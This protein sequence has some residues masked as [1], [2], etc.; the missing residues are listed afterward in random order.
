MSPVENARASTREFATHFLA[1]KW[2]LR[3][4]HVRRTLMVV[5]SGLRSSI[6]VTGGDPAA[7]YGTGWRPCFAGHPSDLA[8]SARLVTKCD[9]SAFVTSS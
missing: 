7:I 4:D 5:A 9:R 2:S 1:L 3:D 6:G 8:L